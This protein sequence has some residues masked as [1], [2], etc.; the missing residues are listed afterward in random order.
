MKWVELGK[1]HEL[2]CL[3]QT[4]CNLALPWSHRHHHV[5]PSAGPGPALIM[6]AFVSLP[7]PTCKV[8]GPALSRY[9]PALSEQP[10]V[11]LCTSKG[12]ETLHI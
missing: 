5:A 2:F 4:H 11:L 3:F 6:S 12:N 10:L 7:V 1:V 8:L 9:S